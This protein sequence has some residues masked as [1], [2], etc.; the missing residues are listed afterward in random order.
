MQQPEQQQQRRSAGGRWRRQLSAVHTTTGTRQHSQRS[1]SFSQCNDAAGQ[2]WYGTA[3]GFSV[4]VFRR[5]LI[6]RQF[7]VG[8]NAD[9]KHAVAA[10]TAAE[11]FFDLVFTS[12]SVSRLISRSPG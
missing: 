3:T 7:V 9:D 10:F 6:R 8:C 12:S 11:V 1:G 2:Q 5:P 4:D